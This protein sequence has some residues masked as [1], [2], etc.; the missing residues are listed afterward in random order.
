MRDPL[1][2]DRADAQR[3][4]VP[5]LHVVHPEERRYTVGTPRNLVT[6]NCSMSR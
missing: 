6:W 3:R 1:P 4:Q 2:A 5:P